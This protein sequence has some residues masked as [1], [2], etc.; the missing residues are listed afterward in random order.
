MNNNIL[1]NTELTSYL[2]EE[3]MLVTELSDIQGHITTDFNNGVPKF[4]KVRSLHTGRVIEFGLTRTRRGI[5]GEVMYW[6]YSIVTTN[7]KGVNVN[8]VRIFND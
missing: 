3:R 6:N 2:K 8:H 7:R 4:I 5:D 1:I